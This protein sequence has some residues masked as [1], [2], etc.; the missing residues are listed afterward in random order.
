MISKLVG[1]RCVGVRRFAQNAGAG[2]DEG[3]VEFAW[4]DGSFLTI[5][6][7][8]DWTLGFSAASWTDPFAKANADQRRELSALGWLWF[9][10]KGVGS[11]QQIEGQSLVS[12]ELKQNTA[13]EVTGVTLEFA[14]STVAAQ[15]NGGDLHVE[16]V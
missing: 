14:R 12:A 1:R 4:D 16:V 6:V 11:L 9:E 15:V 13:G 3:P 7:N 10:C 8:A 2:V 5:D